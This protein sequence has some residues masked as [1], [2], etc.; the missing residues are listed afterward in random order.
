MWEL[1]HKEGWVP[2]N[3]CLWTA[4][5]EKTLESP[6]DCKEI[7]LVNLKGNQYWIF[8]GRAD[9]E[10]EAPILWL[11]NAKSQLTGKDP[12]AGKDWRQKKRLA[13]DE[14]VGW[15]HRLS[16][17]EFEQTLGDSEGQGSLVCC[18]PW[19]HKEVDT[20]E[21]LNNKSKLRSRGCCPPSVNP[22]EERRF[23]D[24]GQPRDYT[25]I[26][27][28]LHFFKALMASSQVLSWNPQ[29]LKYSTTY[30]KTTALVLRTQEIGMSWHKGKRIILY[31]LF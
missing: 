10:A 2:K 25:H 23:E 22:W 6:L 3:W 21:W 29:I 18:S 20:T 16:G 8:I 11:H 5:L 31:S 1:G 28:F 9:A 4:V 27:E 7:K 17:H 14:T 19:G 15:H 30:F 24:S 26:H 12:D 13:E